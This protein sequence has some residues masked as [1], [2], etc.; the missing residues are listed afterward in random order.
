[1]P[2]KS[3]EVWS[4]VEEAARLRRIA[5]ALPVA[6]R[7]AVGTLAR[8]L[9]VAARRDMQQE[10]NLPASRINAGLTVSRTA[11]SVVLQGSK[12][13]IGLVAYGARQ[14]KR[15]V[16]VSIL[17]GKTETWPEAFIAA[18]KNGNRQVFVRKGRERLPIDALYGSSIAT[19]LRKPGRAERLADAAQQVV[20]AEIAR[21]A[22]GGA[23]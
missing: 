3:F 13:G 5:T 12:R 22:G 7:R 6:V 17:R 2:V 15:G 1:M 8:R 14:T 20:S 19:M 11:G 16:V 23:D 4:I 10:Y 21:L 18:G 9:P